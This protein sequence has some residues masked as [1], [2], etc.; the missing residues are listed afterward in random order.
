MLAL[1]PENQHP[2][3]P[4]SGLMCTLLQVATSKNPGALVN[5]V[6]RKRSWDEETSRRRKTMKDLSRGGKWRKC[7][8]KGRQTCRLINKELGDEA[9]KSGY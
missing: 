2:G 6:F 3:S 1:V 7:R 4:L 8:H 5:S 9:N